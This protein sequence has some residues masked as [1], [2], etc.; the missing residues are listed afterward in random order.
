[1]L[2]VTVT[3]RE[4]ISAAGTFSTLVLALAR[5]QWGASEVQVTQRGRDVVVALEDADRAVAMTRNGMIGLTGFVF[6]IT[7][8]II[9]IFVLRFVN[10]PI[11]KLIDGTRQIAKGVYPVQIDIAQYRPCGFDKPHRGVP[12]IGAVLGIALVESRCLPDR[13]DEVGQQ[14]QLRTNGNRRNR[15][16]RLLLS[17]H[18]VLLESAGAR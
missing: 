3:D 15:H 4:Q 14:C 13:F 5:P 2:R 11:T 16:R 12:F 9:L 6:L 1:M 7:S 18:H 10:L 8:A 17:G